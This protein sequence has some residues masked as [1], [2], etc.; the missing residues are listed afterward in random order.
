MVTTA[1]RTRDRILDAA[2]ALVIA[3]GFHAT[4]LDAILTDA[5]VSKGA[6]FH[7]FESKDAL[8]QALVTRYA[9]RD[10]GVL[11]EFMTAAEAETDDPGQQVIAFVRKFEEATY[12]MT[13]VLPGCL[14]VSFIY[15]RGPGLPP[16]GDDVIVESIEVWRNRILE[17]LEQAAPDHP[18]LQEVDLESLANH[19]FTTF[20]GGFVLARATNEWSHLGAQI[21]QTRRYMELLIDG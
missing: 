21:A 12:D 3:H 1:G 20:E 8:G 2:E 17:K 19:V 10:A 13:T 4:T 9:E 18:R 14:F 7:H 16:D 11:E 6:F 15:E 5:D